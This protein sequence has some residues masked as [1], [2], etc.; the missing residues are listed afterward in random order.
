MKPVNLFRVSR[1]GDERL[2]NI[3]EKHEAGDHDNHS[4]RI[5]EIKSLCILADALAGHGASVKD[6]DGFYFGFVIPLIGK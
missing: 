3:M 6:A 5:H 4:I 1:I 2:F